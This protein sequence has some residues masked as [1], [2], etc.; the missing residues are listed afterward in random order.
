MN[1]IVD[2]VQWI[3]SELPYAGAPSIPWALVE[4]LTYSL[5]SVAVAAAIATP[6]GWWIGHTGKG[7]N[8][9]VGLV[10]IGRAIP[11]FGLLV[12]LVLSIGVTRK[13]EAA[14]ATFIILAFAAILA[15]SYAGVASAPRNVVDAARAQGMTEWQILTKVELPLG[16]PLLVAGIRSAF[17]QVIATVTIGAY[18]GLGGLGQYIIAGIPLRQFEMVLGGALLTTALALIVDGLFAILQRRA[19]PAGIATSHPSTIRSQES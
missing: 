2:A 12:L 15:G 1:L 19:H 10:G 17:L 6:I 3:F 13:V 9:I 14:I 7:Q 16:L 11:S 4:H 5:I 8:T 18:V